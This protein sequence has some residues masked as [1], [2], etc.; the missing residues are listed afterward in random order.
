MTSTTS[1]WGM[2]VGGAEVVSP[3]QWTS[4][5]ANRLKSQTDT[6]RF[7]KSMNL[8]WM[9]INAPHRE[10]DTAGHLGILI[11]DGRNRTQLSRA[12]GPTRDYV[13]RLEVN[14]TNRLLHNS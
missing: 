14:Q 10:G 8:Q 7:N 1:T 9:A 5:T 13:H 3:L 6:D 2:G 4:V 11:P 12:T